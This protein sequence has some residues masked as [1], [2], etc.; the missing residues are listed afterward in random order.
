MERHG[1]QNRYA[2]AIWLLRRLGGHHKQLWTA[3]V[4][5]TGNLHCDCA[6]FFRR[7]SGGNRR[8]DLIRKIRK[9]KTDHGQACG[10]P[11]VW[12]HYI[13]LPYG[14]RLR[15]TA[16]GVRR[17]GLE[18]ADADRKHGNPVSADIS[19][20]NHAQYRDPLSGTAGHDRADT[21]SVLQDEKPL[22]CADR[23]GSGSFHSHASLAERNGRGV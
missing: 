13:C 9:N 19:A 20:G 5:G 16:C 11:T 14:D 23:T 21:L 4:C 18:S 17:V 10:L 8:G 12:N 7:I 15:N 2:P 22:S 1:G 6:G 3:A